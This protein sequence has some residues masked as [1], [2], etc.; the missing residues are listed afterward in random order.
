[1]KILGYITGHSAHLSPKFISTQTGLA[2]NRE[3]VSLQ[4]DSIFAESDSQ[5]VKMIFEN[6]LIS[7]DM[8]FHVIFL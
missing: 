1:M 4:R 7:M 2:T 8:H 3:T 6:S 5:W